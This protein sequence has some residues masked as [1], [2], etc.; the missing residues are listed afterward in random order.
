MS[1]RYTKTYGRSSQSNVQ[2]NLAFDDILKEKDA[3]DNKPSTAKAAPTM[4]PWGKTSFT[5]TRGSD[6]SIPLEVETKK[7]QQRRVVVAP[8]RPPEPDMFG[9]PFSFDQEDDGPSGSKR[10]AQQTVVVK[11]PPQTKVYTVTPTKVVEIPQTL[12]TKLVSVPPQQTRVITLT[13]PNKNTH[14]NTHK[15]SQPQLQGTL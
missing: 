2:A 9:D 11:P 14:V 7:P 3:K 10:K 12:T 13:A 1:P 6:A 5:S 8:P 15:L 4:H